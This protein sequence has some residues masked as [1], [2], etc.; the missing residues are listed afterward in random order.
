M[1]KQANEVWIGCMPI[2]LFAIVGFVLLS[3]NL[4]S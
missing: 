4:L 1:K 2:A 3:C